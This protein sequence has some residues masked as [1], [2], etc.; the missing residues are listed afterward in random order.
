MSLQ[1]DIPPTNTSKKIKDFEN[2][3][4]EDGAIG[5]VTVVV[6][7][8]HNKQVLFLKQLFSKTEQGP[9]TIHYNGMLIVVQMEAINSFLQSSLAF[10]KEKWQ[11]LLSRCVSHSVSCKLLHLPPGRE[12]SSS[13]LPSSAAAS[14][15]PWQS[16]AGFY[17]ALLWSSVKG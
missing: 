13:L 2:K 15:Q 5:K 3:L 1:T 8:E 7:D 6:K 14:L 16:R 17:V 10:G 11:K 4:Q 12:S 9:D